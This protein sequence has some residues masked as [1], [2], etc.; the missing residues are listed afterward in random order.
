[1]TPTCIGD[2]CEILACPNHDSDE[3]AGY[4]P[5]WH[6]RSH[7]VATLAEWLVNDVAHDPDY[8][9]NEEVG[10][11]VYA[12]VYDPENYDDEYREMLSSL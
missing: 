9:T 12:V 7:N 2:G 5:D 10:S 1:M 6:K 11:L 8:P 3:P 4:E